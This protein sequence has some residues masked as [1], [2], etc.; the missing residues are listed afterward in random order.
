M[1]MPK[2]KNSKLLWTL[3]AIASTLLAAPNPLIIRSVTDDMS[4]MQLSL[5]RFTIIVILT[6][7]FMIK[8]MQQIKRALQT[9]KS[10]R[11]LL[12]SATSM[13]L[14]I[15]FY[16]EAIALSQASYVSIIVLISPIAIVLLSQKLFGERV[17]KRIAAGLGVAFA[18]AL[19]LVIAPLLLKH[20]SIDFYP[21]AT[22]Y[23]LINVALFSLGIV[24][25]RKAN[26]AGL[27]MTTILGVSSF[28]GVLV[29]GFALI[30]A[31][32]SIQSTFALGMNPD[33][34]LPIL[35]SAIVVALMT[36]AISIVSYEHIG[37]AM[38]AG[39]NYIGSFVAIVLPVFILGESLSI[40]MIIGG[41]LI[42]L[43]ALIVENILSSSHYHWRHVHNHGS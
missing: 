41:T 42:V 43:G 26:E 7:P 1:L 16:C 3:V 38:M 25:M 30:M 21:L 28:V 12:L 14:A 10:I 19:L 24:G 15:V 20:G 5:L 8:N 36:R 32:V 22:L 9:P 31:G 34:L 37:A 18:G 11:W 23:A 4:A 13:A 40:P 2:T 6:L 35:Y 29:T 39:V 33:A 27:S 17:N